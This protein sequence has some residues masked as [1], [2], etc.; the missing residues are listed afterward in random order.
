[1][2]MHVSDIKTAYAVALGPTA[3]SFYDV[4]SKANM[5]KHTPYYFFNHEPTVAIKNAVKSGRL[6]DLKGNI[7]EEKTGT[8]D[9]AAIRKSVKAELES[10]MKA[11]LQAKEA[12]LIEKYSKA[13]E[14]TEEKK[15]RRKADASEK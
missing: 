4:Y 10:E 7:L 13:E 12:E 1:M 3:N 15:S 6:V 2:K 14:A 9:E 8:V 11:K 5:F